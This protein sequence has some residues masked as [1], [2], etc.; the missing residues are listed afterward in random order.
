MLNSFSQQ[1]YSFNKCTSDYSK[2]QINSLVRLDPVD[3][4]Y[5]LTHVRLRVDAITNCELVQIHSSVT[6]YS[7][8]IKIDRKPLS[9]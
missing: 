5:P 1:V 9:G 2:L 8:S 6:Q 4:I 3:C 7:R